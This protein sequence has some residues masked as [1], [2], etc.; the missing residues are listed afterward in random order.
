MR[1]FAATGFAA[2]LIY[3]RPRGCDCSKHI[4]RHSRREVGDAGYA[5]TLSLKS[6]PILQPRHLWSFLSQCMYLPQL[7]LV[8][9]VL[10]VTSDKCYKNWE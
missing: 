2:K 10:I 4:R 1:P 5:G 8:P 3:R 9:S 6:F 7:K